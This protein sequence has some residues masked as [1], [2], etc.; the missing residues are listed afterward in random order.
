MAGYPT[1]IVVTN[2]F[3]KLDNVRVSLAGADVISIIKGMAVLFIYMGGS[4]MRSIK[5]N[6]AIV[7]LV[8]SLLTSVSHPVDMAG[9]TPREDLWDDRG[10]I[11]IV[12]RTMGLAEKKGPV[13]TGKQALYQAIK[14]RGG[15]I[16]EINHWS[17]TDRPSCLIVGTTRNRMV[18]HLL[19]LAVNDM[20]RPE[21]V[22]F[23][24]RKTKD[25]DALV[26]AGT[27]E[28][29]LMYAL[30]E[31][32]D[33]VKSDGLESLNKVENLVEFPDNTVR[34]VDRF[35]DV[36]EFSPWLFSD[37]F[38][39]YYLKRLARNR[40][41]KLA[42]IS[43]YKSGYL[44]PPYPY[45]V[46][47]PGFPDV[48]IKKSSGF[49]D[50]AEHLAQWRRIGELC[51]QHGIDFVLGI[52]LHNRTTWLNNHRTDR[53]LEG[54]PED[55]KQY[56]E[57][58]AKG[59]YEL[60]TSCPEIDGIH[61]RINYESG[62]GKFGQT[63]ENFWREIIDAMGKACRNREEE[64]YID[65]RAKGLTPP[66]IDWA[67]ETG[68]NISIPTKYTWEA[69]GLPYHA[70][71]MRRN[72]LASLDN[73]DLRQRYGYADFLHRPRPFDVVYRLWGTGTHRVLLWGDPDFARRFSQSAGFGDA[74]GFQVTVPLTMNRTNGPLFQNDEYID[75]QWDDERYWAYYLFL[76]R[77]GYSAAAKPEVWEREFRIRFGRA[78]DDIL[79]AYSAAGKFLPL[80]TTAH[81]TKHPGSANWGEADTGAALFGENNF[82]EAHRNTSYQEVEPGDPGMFYEI[83]E[84]VS[85]YLNQSLQDKY[86]PVQLSK[87]LGVMARDT[88][89]SLNAAK[90]LGVPEGRQK[91]FNATLLDLS[92]QAYLAEF[93]QYKMRAAVDLVFYQKTENTAY[94][95]ASYNSMRTATEVWN[96]LVKH[97]AGKYNDKLVFLGRKPSSW[98]D[99]FGEI[100]SDLEKLKSMLE[101]NPAKEAAS[102]MDSVRHDAIFH[103]ADGWTAD[104]PDTHPAGKDLTVTV[105]A[106]ENLKD[107][108]V[109]LYYRRMD[110][111]EG[112]FKT[113]ETVKTESGYRGKIPGDYI[114]D[115]WDLLVYFAARNQT[116][117]TAIIPGLYHPEQPAPYFIVRIENSGERE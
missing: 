34:G 75:Y 62:I 66:M 49:V 63:A 32:A 90:A 59:M 79:N 45:F 100:E 116:G 74:T 9:E 92:I 38:W 25:V 5:S 105:R 98:I 16:R 88:R 70:S 111:T 36:P 85:D 12:D 117:N 43:G 107:R 73:Y 33:R 57:Y 50:R 96:K 86:T 39:Q 110:M 64:V 19:Q 94:L 82:F 84:Y 28:R 81:L 1:K 7:V 3:K 10:G 6:G 108:D 102:H 46:E 51:H 22:V 65:L 83:N 113:A 91:T 20:S 56:S 15:Q 21:G 18:G 99:R 27:D 23:Q 2:Q 53:Y 67:L 93:H 112:K 104:V 26:A 78:A 115:G 76:G 54:L 8:L 42:L 41:N 68:L 89:E 69:T 101:R 114:V 31:L 52:W 44:V 30:F 103:L 4:T 48:Q 24:W 109:R 47:V 14:E 71:T 95:Q 11:V 40:F 55:G 72:E 80:I 77:L 106:K 61:L 35:V 17:Q 29:G 37:D 60:L 58:C 97:T 13:M 87:T